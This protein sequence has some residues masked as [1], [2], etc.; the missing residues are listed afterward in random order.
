VPS[1][2]LAIA[3]CLLYVSVLN[4]AEVYGVF[5]NLQWLLG[6]AA[7]L[8]LVAKPSPKKAWKI[9]DAAVLVALGLSGP[10]IF[11][12]ALVAFFVWRK[13]RGKQQ[14]RNFMLVSVLAAVQLFMLLF[15]S[16]YQRVGG[17]PAMDFFTFVQIVAGQIFT[18]GILGEKN[19]D[20]L[21]QQPWQLYTVFWA[22]LALV[23]Y[24]IIKGPQW[25]KLLNTFAILTIASM[26]LTLKPV[27]G[28][29]VW[30]GLTNPT[31]GQ[32][33]WYFAI[34]ATLANVLWL[35]FAA[36]SRL[37]KVVGAFLLVLLLFF[38]IPQGWKIENRKI[39]DFPYF[40]QQF[41]TMPRGVPYT[42]PINP[43]GWKM[44]LYKN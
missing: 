23:A 36:R 35:A 43:P 11:I 34:L 16:T 33:Y 32:R 20:M 18:G 12:L 21:Y 10:T 42:F 40:V 8:V 37:A 28:F 15:V 26:M 29:D 1:N 3:A 39:L 30:K 5:A 7:F 14:R 41:E 44:I 2:L 31:A 38:G 19:M 4:A 6:P 25:L 13:T 24:V 9:F 27:E 22:G 17:H